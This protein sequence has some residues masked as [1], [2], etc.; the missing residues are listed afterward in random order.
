[1][2]ETTYDVRIWKIQTRKNK[3][4]KITSYRVRWE[5]QRSDHSESFKNKA[6]AESFRADLLRAARKGEAFVVDRGLPVSMLRQVN[7][8][9]WFDFA[10]AYVDMKWPDQSGNSRKGIAETLTTITPALLATERGKP[11]EKVLR[12]ALHGWAFNCSRR[13][14][15]EQPPRVRSALKWLASNTKP[16]SV[17]SDASH[18][19]EALRLISTR[20]DGKQSAASVVSRKRA[21]LYNA[22]DYAVERQLLDRNRL[23]ELKWAPPKSVQAID[24]R[25]VINHQQ[26]TK[27]LDAVGRQEP[28]GS[29]L[30][31]FF[32]VMYYAAARPG[33][34]V[35]LRRSDLMLPSLAHDPATGQWQ[36]PEN[37][38]GELLLSE[39]APETGARWS[40]TGRRRDRRQLKHRGKGDTRPV[41]CP[42]PLVRILRTHTATYPPRPN[43]QLFYGMQGGELPQ[44]TYGHAWERARKAALTPEEYKS[45]LAKRPYDLRHAAVSTWLS[46]GVP[47][48]QVAEWA[49]HSVTVLLQIYAKT[50]AGQEE[51]ARRRVQQLLG[52][53]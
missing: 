41:P 34:A 18:L 42:P 49:G 14:T 21:V 9:S 53:E 31:A 8:M 10:C 33:E 43:G 50:L 23:P 39:S 20:L 30:V 27:L 52:E 2:T 24:K 29:R 15:V 17:L 3:Q 12:D 25:T 28:S 44:S 46:A 51:L 40:T 26:A 48:T 22:L 38:W 11:D 16:V 5:V 47:P 45:P 4:G 13:D 19:R 37:A 36:E 7:E 6:Q 1:M 32:A 35:N